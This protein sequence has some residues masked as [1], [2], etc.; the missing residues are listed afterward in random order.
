MQ[1]YP[2]DF[3]ILIQSFI[4]PFK[5]RL[6]TLMSPFYH[7]PKAR[8]L[9]L[10]VFLLIKFSTY[11]IAHPGSGITIDRYGQI[12]FTDMGMGVWK[13][14]QQ[15]KLTYIP[16]SLFHWLTLDEAGS[17]ANTSKNFGNW[18]ER[19]SPQNSKPALIMCSDFPLTIHPDGN[20]YYADTRPN[21]PRLVRRTPGG[22]ESTLISGQQF[23]FVHGITAG[24]DSNLYISSVSEKFTAIQKI[25]LDGKIS[26]LAQYTGKKNSSQLPS[27]MHPSYCRGLAI[28][29]QGTAY[30]AATGSRCVLKI[31][32]QGVITTLLE[33]PYPWSPTGVAVF[34]DEVYMLEWH[35][36]K[37]GDE[38]I[39]KA[40]IPRIRKLG[41]D[42]KSS[43][44]ATITR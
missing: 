5:I 12:Y 16:A 1:I 2:L 33:V 35:D 39:R 7:W 8:L 14:D 40:W 19:V 32:S 34:N 27:G 28:D 30:V 17:F 36:V 13:I 26:L 21:L 42:G 6:S 18:F 23:Q 44:L 3:R 22:N 24:P 37:A 41:K 25:S 43:I 15:G 10:T 4:S 11:A 20:L 38:E 9:V 29:P 31:T